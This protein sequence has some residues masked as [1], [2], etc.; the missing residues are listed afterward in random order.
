MSINP[1]KIIFGILR[2]IPTFFRLLMGFMLINNGWRWIHRP[3]GSFASLKGEN[4][5]LKARLCLLTGSRPAIYPRFRK[6]Q[7]AGYPQRRTTPPPGSPGPVPV[8]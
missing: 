2:A 5:P 8:L 4:P 1:K 3:G 7:N 6:F